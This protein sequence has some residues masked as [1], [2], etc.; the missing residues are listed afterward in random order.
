MLHGSQGSN[1]LLQ[2]LNLAWDR[3]LTVAGENTLS[4]YDR[5]GCL[6]IIEIA[7]PRND[8][9]RRHFSFFV[10]Q[11]PSPLVQGV[12]CF[13]DLDYFIKCMHGKSLQINFIFLIETIEWVLFFSPMFCSIF[14]M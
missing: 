11:Q 12:I 13:P 4:C 5:E 2:V 3:G 9:D 14:F 6:R 10:Y 1:L 7:K 8:P